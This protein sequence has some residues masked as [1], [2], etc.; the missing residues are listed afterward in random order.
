MKK[1]TFFLSLII[2]IVLG[3]WVVSGS[4]MS[5]PSTSPDGGG[6]I[7]I[8]FVGSLTGGGASY[9][10][11]ISNGIRL[12]MD[13]INSAG[14]VAGGVNVIFEDGKCTNKDALNAARKLIDS[15]KVG[16]IIG[17]VCSG[18]SLGFLPVTEAA[19]VVV[20][21]PS[22]SSPDLTGA[23]EYFFR[24]NPSDAHSGLRLAELVSETHNTVA[25]ISEETDYAQGFKGVFVETFTALGGTIVS[26]EDFVPE[27]DDF[28]SVL[29]KVKEA[30][31]TALVVNPQTSIVGGTI[32]KQAR[33][34]GIDIPLYG[35]NVLSD[36]KAIEIA[37]VDNIEGLVYV[38][39]PGLSDTNDI[40]L[41]FRE[42]FSSRYPSGGLEFYNAAGYDALY[43]L[44]N[45]ILEVGTDPDAIRDHL[46]KVEHNGTL[47][48]YGFDENGDLRGVTFVGKRIV[49]GEAV[50]IE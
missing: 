45:A 11:P 34:L 46:H 41:N 39:P 30:A 42:N 23:G 4:M 24:N 13:E 49:G 37:G 10:Q 36:P 7:T 12:A 44:V 31:P 8:G 48:T 27:T 16:A 18:E 6:P 17:G 14:T 2:I 9:G 35:S 32:V 40:V 21:S 15:D 1:V 25:I 5:N 20:I 50:D 47:G 33:E 3:V 22:S 26:D 19:K 43:I 38:D 28:R 29:T